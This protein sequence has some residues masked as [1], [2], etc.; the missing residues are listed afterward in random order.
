MLKAKTVYRIKGK[1][2]HV[3][4]TQNIRKELEYRT[5]PRGNS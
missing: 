2:E 1:R 5:E 4:H 3:H